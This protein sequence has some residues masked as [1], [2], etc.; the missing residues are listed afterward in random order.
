[1]NDLPLQNQAP[2]LIW[3]T[4]VDEE[5]F[6]SQALINFNASR[7]W[8]LDN[9]SISWE[10]TSSIDGLIG[11]TSQFNANDP[12]A[13]NLQTLSDGIHI[14]TA[15][16]CDDAGHC[17]EQNRTI[18]LSNQPPVIVVSTQPGLFND[19]LEIPI[20]KPLSFSLN[21]TYDPEN[22]TL[23]CT[24]TWP[25]HSVNATNCASYSGNISFADMTI[26]NFIL[27]LSVSDGINQATEWPVE[28]T[29]SNEMPIPSFTVERMGDLSEDEITLTSTSID[30]ENDEI[31]YL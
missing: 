14:V 15:K 25:D 26:T 29:L 3:D 2:F 18:E 6:P 30:P 28:V 24:W 31:Q 9:D 23:T 19:K 21:G 20:T 27:T 11:T 10:W 1:M 17:V 4:P 13:V 7:T 22:D 8:D 12:T 5:I 16:V